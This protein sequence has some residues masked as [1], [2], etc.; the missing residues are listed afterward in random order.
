MDKRTRTRQDFPES[1]MLARD[2]FSQEPGKLYTGSRHGLLRLITQHDQ[3]GTRITSSKLLERSENNGTAFVPKIGRD[4]SEFHSAVV[5]I[6]SGRID[7]SE[8]SHR[9]YAPRI[10]PVIPD[11]S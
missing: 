8:I 4:K 1:S 2:F 9:D 5:G 11:G 6:L 10:Q 3:Q 7:F